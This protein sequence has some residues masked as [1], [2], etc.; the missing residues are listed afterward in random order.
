[1][2]RRNWQGQLM[3]LMGPNGR[4]QV[5]DHVTSSKGEIEM[6]IDGEAPHKPSSTG[7]VHT[8]NKQGYFGSYFPSVFDLKW[9][10]LFRS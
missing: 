2:V 6:V 7:R 5:G 3:F 4:V 9:V 1:M 10:P 8:Q